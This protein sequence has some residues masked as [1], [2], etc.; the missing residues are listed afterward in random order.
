[1]TQ[2]FS[3]SVCDDCENIWTGITGVKCPECGSRN[4]SIRK[5]DFVKNDIIEFADEK[6]L[7][8]KNHGPSGMVKELNSP[9]IIDY[10][11]WFFCGADCKL[12]GHQS[13]PK[14]FTCIE[15][16]KPFSSDDLFLLK[17]IVQVKENLVTAVYRS[18]CC[19][20]DYK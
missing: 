13:R 3:V 10:F 5:Y 17:G 18:P 14:M 2:P 11:R 16:G 15:C 8:I 4:V 7:V 20:A 9:A 12:V 6:F 1:M 19:E